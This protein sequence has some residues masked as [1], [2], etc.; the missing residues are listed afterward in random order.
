MIHLVVVIAGIVSTVLAVALNVP[1]I[2]A[3][4]HGKTKPH[5]FSWIIYTIMNAIVT[6]SQF[7]AGARATVL[8]SFVFL[9]FNFVILALS[10]KYGTRNTSR[11]DWFLFVFSLATIVAWYITKDPAV[12]IWLTVIIDI[13]ATTMIILKI[14]KLPN[15]E[16]AKAWIIGVLAY[17]FTCLALVDKPF[18]V[19]YVRPIYGLITDA[20]IVAA[21]F[22]YA[23][24]IPRTKRYTL[25]DALPPSIE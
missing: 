1:Y 19:L 10:F 18:G 3:I 24:K 9:L 22:Y 21:I 15:S 8:V 4:L 5:Q 14:R 23:G 6:V 13:C 17:V 7:M 16:D 11:L 20:L 25:K 2:R 12:A